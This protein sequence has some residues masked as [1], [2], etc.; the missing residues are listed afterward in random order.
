MREYG[1]I[2]TEFW[3]N[4]KVRRLS[5]DA[6]LMLTYLIA[7][8][9][10][11]S[12][13]CFVIPNGYMVEDLDWTAARVASTVAE[14]LSNGSVYRDESV[15]VVRIAGWWDHNS[16]ENPNVARS[17]MSSWDKL[18]DCPQKAEA[19]IGLLGITHRLNNSSVTVLE[20]F[21]KR[22][23]NNDPEPEP[24]TEPEPKPRP[25]TAL[26]ALALHEA[27]EATLFAAGLRENTNGL[28]GPTVKGWLE[29]GARLGEDIVP[30]IERI[31][32]H[33]TAGGKPLPGNLQY[34]TGAIFDDIERRKGS[35]PPVKPE[36]RRKTMTE[37]LAELGVQSV[38]E[39]SSQNAA[40]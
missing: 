24:E 21:V 7:C 29:R 15:R 13:G 34:Y 33:K 23:R 6:K 36:P 4:E 3:R 18:P 25:K 2:K 20:Q 35:G 10:G 17:A 8:P 12:I 11:N 16:I 22:F 1:K 31:I 32:K 27:V 37:A 19:A 39:R 14:L 28:D 9:H 26:N 40:G 30:T 5:N 38:T